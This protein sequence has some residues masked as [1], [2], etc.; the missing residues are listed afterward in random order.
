MSRKEYAAAP[1]WQDTKAQIMANDATI[2]VALA[3]R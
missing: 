1:T 2:G 3:R